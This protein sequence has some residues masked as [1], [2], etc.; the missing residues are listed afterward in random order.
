MYQNVGKQE[1]ITS[2][3]MVVDLYFSSCFAHPRLINN[4]ETSL[5]LSLCIPK[6]FLI[7]IKYKG[8]G[9]STK[10]KFFVNAN[11]NFALR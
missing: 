11:K 7:E 3:V 1:E 8:E 4:L 6:W 10:R 9:Q 5:K 2:L